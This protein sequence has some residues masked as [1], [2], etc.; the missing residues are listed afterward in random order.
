MVNI[1]DT[2]PSAIGRQT[3]QDDV[4][5]EFHLDEAYEKGMTILYFF[6]AAFTG[7]CTRS[8][9]ELRDDLAEFS[10]LGA[11]IYGISTDMPF[12]HNVFAEMNNINY[13]LLSDWNKDIIEAYGI[14]DDNFGGMRGVAKRSLFLIN[15]KK[16]VFKWIGE[17]P[18]KYPPF[19]ELKQQ[20]YELNKNK[21][22]L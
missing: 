18:G 16:I 11:K 10:E 17:H 21:S 5:S 13:P 4:N 12:S 15:D 3:F 2:A 7:V 8:S 14:R 1:G 20:L 19:D 6:P 9:C 22:Q